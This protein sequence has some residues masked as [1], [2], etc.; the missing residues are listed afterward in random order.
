MATLLDW[1]VPRGPMVV[2]V[3]PELV[4]TSAASAAEEGGWKYTE[5]ESPKETGTPQNEEEGREKSVVLEEGDVELN[6][7]E[8]DLRAFRSGTYALGRQFLNPFLP[9]NSGL[10]LSFI[11]VGIASY[12]LYAPVS[13][14]LINS[15]DASSAQFSAF[16][17]LAT[18]PWSL[19]FIFGIV[20]D[21]YPIFGY[22]RK[23][24]LFIGWALYMIFM[25]RTAFQAHHSIMGITIVFFLATCC[26]LLSDVCTDTMCVERSR[27]FEP[28]FKKG[29][30]QTSGYTSRAFG[31]IIGAALGAVL[32]NTT[33]WGW[34]LSI[35][36]LFLLAGLLPLF[37]L[38]P[39]LFSLVEIRTIRGEDGDDGV[40]VL[41]RGS[42]PPSRTPSLGDQFASLWT[43][44]QLEAVYRPLGFLCIMYIMQVPN[45]S[46]TNFLVVG[47]NFSDYDVGII[48]VAGCVFQWLGM[49]VFRVFLFRTPWRRVFLFTTAVTIF[50]SLLQVL[51]I[52]RVNVALGI[53]DIVFALGDTAAVQFTLAVQ[54]MPSSIIFV[55]LCPEG[56][57]GVTY[58]L[59]TTVGNMAWT[60][61]QDLGTSLTSLFD[62]S[63]AALARQDFSGVLKLTILTSVIQIAPIL[64]LRMLPANKSQ[65]EALIRK[66]V[67]SR[68]GGAA[69]VAVLV[70]GL[71]ISLLL[72]VYYIL[73]A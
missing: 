32:Y 4:T 65:H 54:G 68:L 39:S 8:G 60:L 61:A 66:R 72:N 14:Y 17:T 34:G 3:P 73:H 70:L 30:L 52:L 12:F 71:G 58:A 47:L 21:T 43:T 56:A 53:P 57:E 27:A 1:F 41:P 46:W 26:F 36:H 2:S 11:N 40:K 62:C 59:L 44:L 23:S 63:N 22:K 13:F 35:N 45:A 19:K 48:S 64:F 38:L 50:F 15:L 25:C 37:P 28:R 31:S 67:S 16:S 10:T 49:V 18:L 6:D 51:L 24:W 29:S 20:S 42:A 9:Q 55:M 5:L 69:L 33:E 7:D